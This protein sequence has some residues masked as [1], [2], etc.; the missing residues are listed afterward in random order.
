MFIIIISI[1]I[2]LFFLMF[3]F[4]MMVWIGQSIINGEFIEMFHGIQWRI[5]LWLSII[6]IIYRWSIKKNVYDD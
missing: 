2:I 5:S 3:C 6:S 1:K 4:L